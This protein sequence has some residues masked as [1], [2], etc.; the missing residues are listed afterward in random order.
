M[1]PRALTDTINAGM[2][3]AL[4]VSLYVKGR[5]YRGEISVI[6]A[7]QYAFRLGRF[8]AS[9][10]PGLALGD[11]SAAHLLEWQEII[12][13]QRPA[14]RR[15]HL[16]TVQHFCQWATAEGLLSQDPSV[17]LS[18][19]RE[20]KRPPRALS[21]AQ[22]RRLTLALPDDRA[23][24]IVALMV[25]LGLR[26]VE[27]ARL[28]VEDWDQ[29]A[30]EIHVVGK[31]DNERDLPV[32][33]DVTEALARHLAGRQRGLVIGSTAHRVSLEVSRWFGAAG[34]KVGPYDGNSAHAL[35]HTAASN[36]LDACGNVR[37]VQAFLGHT[38]LATT[39]RYLRRP[40][41]DAIRAALGD[42][43]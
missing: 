11:L 8:V 39:Q 40:S 3:V 32:P 13:W 22:V 31:G 18:P 4:V 23:R 12:G 42:T 7:R 5:F 24:A 10:P 28:R 21:V 37:T 17:R 41:L 2:P 34:L 19:V 14:S 27:V 15:A 16:S 25:R 29:D 20:P 33:A 35:R 1:H 30:Q 26:C 36:M 43:G 6:S 9:L 38:S